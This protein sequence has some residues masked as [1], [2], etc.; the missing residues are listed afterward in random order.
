MEIPIGIESVLQ[1][2][3]SIQKLYEYQEKSRALEWPCPNKMKDLLKKIK[4]YGHR[5]VYDE[6][7]T[8]N[9][10]AA[11]CSLRDSYQI[12]QL[13]QM[14]EDLW[15]S[16]RKTSL[17]DAFCIASRHQMLLRDQDLRNLN[18]SDCF[19]QTAPNFY[20]QTEGTQ[21][22]LAMVFCLDKGKTLKEGERNYACAIRHKNVHRCAISWCAFYL[23]SLLQVSSKPETKF[24]RLECLYFFI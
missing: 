19:Y 12:E 22:M 13:S 2:K 8:T 5:L 7:S 20:Q 11:N 15:Q 6:I 10:R 3:K 23:F 1:Y 17:R 16:K 14:L 4:N 24:K 21:K 18:Y 9:E